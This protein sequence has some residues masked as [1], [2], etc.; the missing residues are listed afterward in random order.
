MPLYVLR[1][2]DVALFQNGP[3]AA[4]AGWLSA[5]GFDATLGELRLLPAPGGGVAGAVVG[6]GSAQARRRTR[7]GLAKAFPGLP[8]GNWALTGKL[9]RDEAAEAALGW[10]LAGYRFDRYRPAGRPAPFPALSVRQVW[11]LPD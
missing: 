3:G 4:W 1:P 6:F 11:T 5:T 9:A 10:L 2:E 8:A 7:F